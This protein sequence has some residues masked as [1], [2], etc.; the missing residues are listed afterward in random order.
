[1]ISLIHLNHGLDRDSMVSMAEAFALPRKG[2]LMKLYSVY[3]VIATITVLSPGP[4]VVM[5]LTNSLHY[6]LRGAFGG[7]LGISFGALVIA[8][9]SATSVGILLGNSPLAFTVLKFI[10]AG[11]L[12]YLGIRLWRAPVSHFAT[13]A[14][15]QKGFRRNFLAGMTLQFTNPKAIF[16]FLSVLPQFV[17]RAQSVTA[18]LCLLAMT[19]SLLIIVLHSLYALGAQRTRPWLTSERGAAIINRLGGTVFVMFGALLAVSTR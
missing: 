12:A 5:T 3:F 8:A 19:Y 13:P 2:R 14:G 15:Y 9:V 7:I 4:G 11:Y 16:F 6:G 18:Q 17:D 10:G 1:M